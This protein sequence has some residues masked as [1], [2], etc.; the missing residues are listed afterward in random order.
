MQ[1]DILPTLVK[2]LFNLP[3]LII[4]SLVLLNIILG[5][6]RGFFGALYGLVGKIITLAAA[7]FA[8]RAAAPILAKWVVTPIVGDIFEKQAS[9]SSASGL[10]DGL[11]QTVTE[12][13][14]SMAESIAFLLLFLLAAILFGWIVTLVAKSMHFLAHLTPLGILDSLAGG[15]LGLVT[16]I[17]LIAMLLIGINWF[18]PITFTSL[19]YLSPERVSH[20][21][22]LAQLIDVLPIAI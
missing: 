7:F 15:A 13:A 1:T 12:A 19:G 8:A 20:T 18:S 9:V 6:R 21:V 11:R 17:A 3:D 5:F 22:L 16:G 2:Q 10:L 4:L 14:I